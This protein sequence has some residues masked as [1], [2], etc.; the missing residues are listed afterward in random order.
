MSEPAGTMQAPAVSSF[1]MIRTL[2]LIAMF[3]GLTVVLV[4]Q[5]TLPIIA[6]NQRRA[7]ERAVFEV[8]P[9]ATQRV[10]FV[11]NDAGAFPAGGDATGEVVYAAYDDAGELKGIALEG[12]AQGYQDV[13][14]LIYGYDPACACI[15]G[16]KILKMTETPGLGDKIATDP[17]FLANFDALD[18]KLDP[19]GAQLVHPITTVKA[20]TRA[21]PWEIDAISGA[22]VSSV[23]V[24]KA[25]NASMQRM[26]PLIERHL[27]AIRA[28]GRQ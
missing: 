24:G 22:T 23:A 27:D 11:V 1:R 13:I 4:Y 16:I 14:R 12:G 19:T 5:W 20:G 3:S 7:I 28:G 15:R 10:D 18:A 25:L 2:G 17:A 26:A 6:E 9:G 8:V 21:N